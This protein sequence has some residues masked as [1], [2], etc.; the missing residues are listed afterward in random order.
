VMQLLKVDLD[1]LSDST[2]A[3]DRGET[4]SLHAT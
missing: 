4:R 1:I 3:Y 2:T